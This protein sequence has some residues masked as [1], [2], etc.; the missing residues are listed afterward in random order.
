MTVFNAS[1]E[2]LDLIR[3]IAMAEGLF[4]WKPEEKVL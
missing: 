2:L 4:V 3:P 1:E